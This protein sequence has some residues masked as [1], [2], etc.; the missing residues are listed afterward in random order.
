M[1]YDL[2]SILPVIIIVSIIIKHF[3][4]IESTL[5]ITN[6]ENNSL[7]HSSYTTKNIGIRKRIL[8]AAANNNLLNFDVKGTIVLAVMI[9]S[10]IF[11]LTLIQSENSK[12]KLLDKL[13][14]FLLF[15][16]SILSFFIFIIVEKRSSFSLININLI[17]LKPIMLTNI[18]ILIWGIS[19]FTIFQTIP[20]L[21]RT[22]IPWVS[23]EMY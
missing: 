3:V 4:I 23:V 20:V 8:D 22:P 2:F 17:T 18:L 9:I 13:I 11:A 21:V 1:A 19:T 6:R 10:L 12:D 5:P 15:A 7:T 16:V 14:P